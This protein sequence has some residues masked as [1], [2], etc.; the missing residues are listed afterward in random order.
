[1]E[2]LPSKIELKVGEIY[3][4]RLP[5]LGS[6]G[7]LWEYRITGSEQVVRMTA[8]GARQVPKA[9]GD[10]QMP[11]SYSAD[12]LFH[13][14][15]LEQGQVRIDLLLRRPWEKDTPPLREHTLEVSVSPGQEE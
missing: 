2:T 13:F 14:Y 8:E 7:Y 11:R 3:T 10:E 4:L 6:A 1:M 15:A 5:G 12:I 9:G